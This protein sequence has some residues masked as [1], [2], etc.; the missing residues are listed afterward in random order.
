MPLCTVEQA[1]AAPLPP[2]MRLTVTL[3]VPLP[4]L[5]PP[6]HIPALLPTLAAAAVPPKFK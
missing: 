1:T 2:N 6:T 4:C 5:R 3:V